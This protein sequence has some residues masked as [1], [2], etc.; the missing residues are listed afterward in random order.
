[1]T[2][3]KTYLNWSSGKD[4]AL[5][6]HYLQQD[7]NY[8]VTHLLTAVNAYHNRVSM[9][10]VRRE[11]LQQQ[12]A[13]TGL[14]FSTIELSEQPNMQE[15][16]AAMESIILRLKEQGFTHAAFGDIF[17]EDLRQYRE[18]QLRRLGMQTS[19]PLWKKDTRQLLEEM[20]D[21][22][23]KAIIVCINAQLLPEEFCGRIID[24]S[25]LEDLPPHIDSC[26]ENGEFHTFCF[27]GPVFKKPVP[28][29]I[30]EK[31]YREY[32]S[33]AA[34]ATGDECF[35]TPQQTNVGFWFCDLLPI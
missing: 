18:D 23:F 22:G 28:F 17:L 5:A 30:G 13:A 32:K 15:Y 14:S 35:T 9:H 33:P 6:L 26:G 1:M 11:L 10:G 31:V 21:L 24:K 25:F 16:E 2:I 12:I 7:K 8:E 20:I 34:T 19:F 29:T 3:H 4:A 27:D